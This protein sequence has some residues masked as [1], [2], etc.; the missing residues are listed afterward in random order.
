MKKIKLS[1][2]V[3]AAVAMMPFIQGR[4]LLLLGGVAAG[5]AYGTVKYVNN[6][7]QVSQEVA[8]DKSW[9]AANANCTCP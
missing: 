4:A 2:L 3:I 6:T 5:A 1:V 9:D 7:L 8:L